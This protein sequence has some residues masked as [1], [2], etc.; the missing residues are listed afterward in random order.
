[1]QEIGEYFPLG[2]FF[3]SNIYSLSIRLEYYILQLSIF[4]QF[5]SCGKH[6]QVQRFVYRIF[7]EFS[8]KKERNFQLSHRKHGLL[9][10]P[11]IY[12]DLY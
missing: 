12:C 8:T 9:I 3:L 4:M 2:D 7:R 10:F 11:T 5:S 1:M 6:Y